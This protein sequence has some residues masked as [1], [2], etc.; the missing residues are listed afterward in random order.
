M[1]AYSRRLLG[2]TEITSKQR[3]KDL[4]WWTPWNGCHLLKFPQHVSNIE[5]NTNS[6]ISSLCF[7]SWSVNYVLLR[8]FPIFMFANKIAGASVA[9]AGLASAEFAKSL[10][11]KRS[12]RSYRGCCVLGVRDLRQNHCVRLWCVSTMGLYWICMIGVSYFI[13]EY[14]LEGSYSVRRLFSVKTRRWKQHRKQSTR[15]QYPPSR[16]EH[17]VHDHRQRGF[18]R[19]EIIRWFRQRVVTS[20]LNRYFLKVQCW[21]IWSSIRSFE[22]FLKGS[23][24]R[25]QARTHGC[26]ELRRRYWVSRV[27]VRNH[28]FHPP[29]CS[30]IAQELRYIDWVATTPL[31]CIRIGASQDAMVGSVR[32][33][34]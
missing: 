7:L 15:T 8:N 22:A 10:T 1:F 23:H 17:R 5:W 21:W 13:S 6:Y 4:A 16:Q 26:S 2:F 3:S 29:I 9:F 18:R 12:Y 33:G 24:V 11:L 32:S 28:H 14:I 30:K 34:L 27:P 19:G 25:W 31:Y 20:W